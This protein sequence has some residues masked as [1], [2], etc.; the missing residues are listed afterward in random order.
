MK[1]SNHILILLLSFV[2]ASCGSAGKLDRSMAPKPGPAPAI[3]IPEYQDF[4]LEN[5]LQ[6]I[7]VE[8]HKLPSVSY[9]LSLDYEA[10]LEG[11]KAGYVSMA[12]DLMRKGTSSRSKAEIDESI[13]FIGAS[14]STF[15]SGMFGRSLKKHSGELL[16][17]MQDVLMNPTF[18][19]AELE[20]SKTQTISELASGKT[21][22][23]SMMSNVRG[24]VNYGINHPYGEV[25]TEKTVENIT[26]DDLVSFYNS[27]WKP[28]YSYLVIVGDITLE[29]AKENAN[30]HFGDWQKGELPNLKFKAHS[31][32]EQNKVVFVPLKAAV[33]STISVSYPV[34]LKPGAPDALAANVMNTILGGG[35]F[36]GRLMQNLR[37]DKGYTYGSR[38]SLSSDR[39]VGSFNAGASVRNEVTDSSVYEIIYE[40]KRMINEPV[41]DSI[42]TFVKNSMSGGFARSL[43]NPRTVA[44]FALNTF[45]YD[46][47]KDYYNTYLQRLEALT[48]ADITAAAI[49]YIKP[50]NCNIIVVGNKTE[51]DKLAKFSGENKVWKFDQYGQEWKDME[52][53][54]EGMT[55]ADVIKA[56]EE[57]LG[58]KNSLAAIKS[59]KQE[60][61]MGFMGQFMPVNIVSEIGGRYTAII[62]Q[63]PMILSDIRF[64]GEDGTISQGGQAPTP[65]D[66]ELK[67]TYKLQSHLFPE[68]QYQAFGY[69][70]E[71]DGISEVNGERA[72]VLT[73]T[74]P[75]GKIHTE[76]Y[77]VD[78]GLKI[79]EETM[80]SHPQMGEYMSA[81]VYN[82]YMTVEGIKI[83]NSITQIEG[84][85]QFEITV[86]SISINPELKDSDF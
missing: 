32:P 25:I 46:L 62:G 81:T 51:A 14:L 5:G 9:Q 27:H 76:Y 49:K 67:A 48:P 42:L 34:D 37:E 21:E 11:D 63:S 12:G 65:F 77:S 17:I 1:N 45:R 79:K 60:G 61:K 53:A 2:L 30:K 38:S 85:Q 36:S 84:S 83:P 72:Y 75:L 7:V 3:Q 71:L 8:N 40:L 59:Y 55:S 23:N 78:T 69:S 16:T 73:V 44:R 68:L 10:V 33:Q 18:P 22:P 4:T 15:S 80:E 57:A 39:L 35:V 74:S 26:R 43:E 50:E 64:D 13:D 47:P 58:G 41:N 70:L 31:N 29:E 66:E 19:T 24:V 52:A 20:K 86:S 82:S 6:V 56:Y 54:P 28:N